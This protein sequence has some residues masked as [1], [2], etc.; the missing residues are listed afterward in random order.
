MEERVLKRGLLYRVA[1]TYGSLSY[2]ETNICE[3]IKNIVIGL[4]AIAV[5]IGLGS[6]AG[7]LIVDPFLWITA[8]LIHGVWISPGDFTQITMII[9]AAAILYLI[10][11]SLF[12]GAKVVSEVKTVAAIKDSIAGKYCFP[13]KFE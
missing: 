11:V 12:K 9:V 10:C 2:D 3:L 7:L 8:M 6:I 13:I 4:A 5:I 1:N